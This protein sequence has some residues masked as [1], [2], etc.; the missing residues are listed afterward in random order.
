M[1]HD[2]ELFHYYHQDVINKGYGKK[3]FFQFGRKNKREIVLKDVMDDV[4]AF[5]ESCRKQYDVVEEYSVIRDEYNEHKKEYRI[6]IIGEDGRIGFFFQ[7]RAPLS[8][9]ERLKARAGPMRRVKP[10]RF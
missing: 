7:L 10:Q 9:D 8:I 6:F 1:M 4:R 5:K 3:R 2:V